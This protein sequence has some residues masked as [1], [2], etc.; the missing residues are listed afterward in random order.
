MKL[1]KYIDNK[2]P[3]VLLLFT[4]A[5]M[6][7]CLLAG[8][9][10]TGII[11]LVYSGGDA[12]VLSSPLTMDIN[13]LRMMQIIQSIS[14]F[15]IPPF[16]VARLVEVNGFEFIS[17]RKKA[18]SNLVLL[19]VLLIVA[20]LPLIN[21][22]GLLNNS[23]KLPAFMSGIEQWMKK[24]ETSNGELMEKL[25]DTASIGGLALNL[26]M[27]A[28]LPAFSEEFIFR[29]T[30]QQIFVKLFKNTH[31]GIIFTAALFSAIH[32]QFYGFVPR[33]VLG[34]MFGYILLWS[35]NIWYPVIAH[36]V[37]NA[38]AILYYFYSKDVIAPKVNL[39][40]LGATPDT[41]NV[42]V[43]SAIIVAAILF[44]LYKLCKVKRDLASGHC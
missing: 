23:M 27:M 37:N 29:G 1:F 20:C 31:I 35:N 11:A 26:F 36:F 41:F 43:V 16:I 30:F 21:Y 7:L 38:M 17:V 32:F 5:S 8:T 40:T 28:L 9:L 6:A 13:L 2:S 22:L 4:I 10:I 34:L 3:W 33:M 44:L 39:D 15:L 24:M 42:A 18:D 25:L 12:S 19:S 14:L